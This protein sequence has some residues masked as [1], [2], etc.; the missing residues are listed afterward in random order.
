MAS[1][2]PAGAPKCFSAQ[3]KGRRGETHVGVHPRRPTLRRG[4]AKRQS[5]Q[6]LVF[7][8][9]PPGAFG[10]AGPLSRLPRLSQPS[11][12]PPAPA[13]EKGRTSEKPLLSRRRIEWTPPGPV[14]SGH[15]ASKSR[16][17]F[18]LSCPA[19]PCY[20]L[21]CPAASIPGTAEIARGTVLR[22]SPRGEAK[23]SPSGRRPPKI[24]PLPVGDDHQ[25]FSLS[26]LETTTKNSPSPRWR[27]PPKIL[28]L[29]LGEGW[30]EGA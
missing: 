12:M 21:P 14:C 13:R 18:S 5:A 17:G 29:P 7:R 24:L 1:G 26:L 6:Q 11:V 28:P 16:T 27:G 4:S 19:L 9:K 23:T 22:N 15:D 25:K 30:G 2:A 20:V 8:E 10:R 3:Q